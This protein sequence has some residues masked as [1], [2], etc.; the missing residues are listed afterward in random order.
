MNFHRLSLCFSYHS[1]AV[2]VFSSTDIACQSAIISAMSRSVM[3]SVWMGSC[4]LSR[5]FGSMVTS[6]LS[7]WLSGWCLLVITWCWVACWICFLWSVFVGFPS[8]SC[9]FCQVRWM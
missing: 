1:R 8:C 7:T 5:S 2:L 9:F 4:S 3:L 6:D